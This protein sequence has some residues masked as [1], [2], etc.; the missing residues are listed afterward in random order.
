MRIGRKKIREIFRSETSL[1]LSSNGIDEILRWL[2]ELIRLL[3]RNSAQIAKQNNRKTILLRDIAL[4][5]Y[6]VI[7]SIAYKEEF[8]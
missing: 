6:L 2:E 3:A 5:E 1:R 8:E 7:S 4:A